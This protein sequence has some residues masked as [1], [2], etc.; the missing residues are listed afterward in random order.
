MPS[1]PTN[2]GPVLAAMQLT[3]SALPIGAF[4]HSLGFESY[5]HDGRIT[6]ASSFATWLE[7]F[8][9]QQLTFSDALAIRLVYA[10]HSFTDVELI[11]ARLVAQTLPQQIR[12]AAVAM[13]Q[14]LLAI[15]S[16]SYAGSWLTT[17][18][19]QVVAKQLHGHQCS[20][21]AVAA[22]EC[23][24][25]VD[26]AVA[27]HLYATLISLTQNAVRGIPLG[28]NAGQ[29]IIFT[30]QSWVKTA[31]EKSATLTKEDFGAVAPGL[32]IAQMRH[33]QQRARLFM[34]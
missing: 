15:A 1:T 32:E 26:T 34:S 25:D 22:K 19:Q 27:Q 11:D 33:E 29:R 17:Y 13:G 4:S 20:V 7:M 9:A 2:L 18:Q 6:D 23:G 16:E 12:N 10:A 31:V 21:W 24:I 5:I 3:D 28:Q 8:C 30:A 14:R